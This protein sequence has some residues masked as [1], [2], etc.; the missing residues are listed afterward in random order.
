MLD[1]E[2]ESEKTAGLKRLRETNSRVTIGIESA[3]RRILD[4]IKRTHGLA[5][6]IYSDAPENR[7]GFSAHRGD[8]LF[9]TRIRMSELFGLFRVDQGQRRT[10]IDQPPTRLWLTLQCCLDVKTAMQDR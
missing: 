10:R 2:I 5:G 7:V 3:E 9:N 1:K 6:N 8:L 4:E